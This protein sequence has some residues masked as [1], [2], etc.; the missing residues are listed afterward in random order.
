M[1]TNMNKLRAVFTQMSIEAANLAAERMQE[2][3]HTMADLIVSKYY[4]N[5]TPRFYQ[6]SFGL[7]KTINDD[8]SLTTGL[9]DAIANIMVNSSK[10][11]NWYVDGADTV[12]ELAMNQGI[13]GST[14]VPERMTPPPLAEIEA[15]YKILLAERAAVAHQAMSE[16]AGKY[17][18]KIAQAVK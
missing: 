1:A 13:H 2:K 15:E 10:M 5:Y 3:L 6:R 8:L 18:S 4:E 16:V 9:S 17:A 11:G 14:R 12:F 7:H